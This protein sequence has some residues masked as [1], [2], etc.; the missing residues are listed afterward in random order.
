MEEA[1]AL[2]EKAQTEA[3]KQ[4]RRQLQEAKSLSGQPIFNLGC[5]EALAGNIDTALDEL[6]ACYTAGSLTDAADLDADTDLD[7]L[8]DHPRYK[9]LRDQLS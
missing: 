6:E 5:L 9:A 1:K 7:P 4:A 3:F 8:R 2:S